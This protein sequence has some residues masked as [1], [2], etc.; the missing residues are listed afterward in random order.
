MTSWILLGFAALVLG[1]I[2]WRRALT[3][4]GLE[5]RIRD[6]MDGGFT[7][8]MRKRCSPGEVRIFDFLFACDTSEASAALA[9]LVA[10]LGYEVQIERE[11]E[12]SELLTASVSRSVAEMDFSQARQSFAML[13]LPAGSHYLGLGAASYEAAG[14]NVP[15]S[16]TAQTLSSRRWFDSS[17]GPRRF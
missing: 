13:A 17:R 12:G 1:Y 16:G 14:V 5:Q 2:G 9:T 6:G 10:A 15:V 11:P 4:P 3:R 7:K 8:M